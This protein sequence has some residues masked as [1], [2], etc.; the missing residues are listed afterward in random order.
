MLPYLLSIEPTVW[1]CEKRKK[2]ACAGLRCM[3][4]QKRCGTRTS[5]FRVVFWG[6]GNLVPVP[7][8]DG[9]KAQKHCDD[10]CVCL[11]ETWTMRVGSREMISSRQVSPASMH[12]CWCI[13][14]GASMLVI[15]M[16]VISMI[17]FPNITSHLF[18]VRAARVDPLKF[19]IPALVP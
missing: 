4:V 15:S 11:Q 14:A 7:E 17:D 16:L 8:D 13:D 12:Q 6:K 19:P 18:A 5:C 9:S 10:S 2:I 3:I 1:L